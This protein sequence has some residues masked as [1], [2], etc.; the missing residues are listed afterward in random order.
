MAHVVAVC[1]SQNRSDPKVDV[2]AGELR[3]G[4]GLVGD[5]HAGYSER[6]ISVLG[7]ESIE[8]VNREHP[9]GA[10]PGSFAE[11]LTVAGVDLLTL[12]LGDHLQVGPSLLEVVQIGK[13]LDAAHTYNYKG[14][15]IL[16]RKGVF[17]RVVRG[18]LVSRGDPVRIWPKDKP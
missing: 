18:G 1:A 10:V 7:V 9:I 3:A 12:E 4:Y 8:E 5:A 14:V 2:G 17:C 13:P 11:N 15:S 16:P 6:E